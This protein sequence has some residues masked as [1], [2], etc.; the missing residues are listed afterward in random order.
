MLTL[1]DILKNSSPCTRAGP[2]WS[3]SWGCKGDDP[4][5]SCLHPNSLSQVDLHHQKLSC[6]CPAFSLSLSLSLGSTTGLQGRLSLWSGRSS[7]RCG[8]PSLLDHDLRGLPNLA[9]SLS[10]KWA[11]SKFQAFQYFH[12]DHVTANKSNRCHFVFC[13]HYFSTDHPT[14]GWGTASEYCLQVISYI[15][16]FCTLF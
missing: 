15:L 4:T 10:T 5:H 12:R 9:K 3:D 11:F 2:W 16:L 1:K 7:W 6:L 8:R 13:K 14:A